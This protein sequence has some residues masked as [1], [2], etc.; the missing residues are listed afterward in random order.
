MQER[1]QLSELIDRLVIV[2]EHAPTKTTYERGRSD[3]SLS[4]ELLSILTEL[5]AIV[6]YESTEIEPEPSA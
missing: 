4:Y 1:Q 5:K 6:N 2:Q 3:N